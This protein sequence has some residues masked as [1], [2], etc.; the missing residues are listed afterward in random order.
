MVQVY[1][2]WKSDRSVQDVFG[3]PKP[4]VWSPIGPVP[5]LE[6]WPKPRIHRL[7]VSLHK[8]KLHNAAVSNSQS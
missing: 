8:V 5:G 2:P 3:S 1:F 4:V 6:V 7:E